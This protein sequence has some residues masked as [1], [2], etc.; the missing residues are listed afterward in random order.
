M[1]LQQVITHRE[2]CVIH[3]L[4]MHIVSTSPGIMGVDSQPKGLLITIKEASRRHEQF[5]KLFLNYDGTYFQEGGL[6]IISPQ[7]NINMMARCVECQ[8]IPIVKGKPVVATTILDLDTNSHFFTF[9]IKEVGQGRF[10]CSLQEEVFK[11][12]DSG[13]FYHANA[14]LIDGSGVLKMGTYDGKSTLDQILESC[15]I[16][17]MPK[18]DVS[19]ISTINQ[20]IEKIKLYNLFS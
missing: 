2:K 5:H 14:N 1:N 4:P 15:M 8:I 10:D 19:K 7:Q 18:F 17:N 9:S 6:E 3:N 16:F 20:L 11:F 13:K 12:F